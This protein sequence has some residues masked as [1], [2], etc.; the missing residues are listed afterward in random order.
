MDR[1]EEFDFRRCSIR[2]SISGVNLVF[3]SLLFFV[4]LKGFQVHVKSQQWLFFCVIFS[5]G[6]VAVPPS[7]SLYGSG[8]SVHAVRLVSVEHGSII[9]VIVVSGCDGLICIFGFMNN[10]S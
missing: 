2:L 10:S 9:T 7:T 5:A 1:I 8:M 3:E 6:P 4:F